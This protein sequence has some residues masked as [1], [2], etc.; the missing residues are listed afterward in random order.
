MHSFVFAVLFIPSNS[1]ALCGYFCVSLFLLVVNTV[2]ILIN[3][4][5][6]LLQGVSENVFLYQEYFR[7]D[8]FVNNRHAKCLKVRQPRET[9]QAP[10][11]GKLLN[12]NVSVN[13]NNPF[14]I[15]GARNRLHQKCY[16]NY[17]KNSK[18]TLGLTRKFISPPWYKAGGGGGV[19][20]AP[21][22]SFWYI[23]IFGN[24]FIFSGK[25]LI[26]LTSWG[27]FYGWWRF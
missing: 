3:F 17:V 22:R 25:P 1:S 6:Q 24:D 27:I 15:V 10:W 14:V 21:P 13:Q 18:L 2:R 23:A 11:S 7:G 8:D 16:T 26:F 9:N 4:V 19:D 20:G 5:T 12:G